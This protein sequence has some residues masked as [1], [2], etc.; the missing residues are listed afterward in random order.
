MGD[1]EEYAGAYI[2][3]G[4]GCFSGCRIELCEFLSYFGGHCAL[5]GYRFGN[6]IS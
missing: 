6:G 5:E 2:V 3:V 1:F 4:F